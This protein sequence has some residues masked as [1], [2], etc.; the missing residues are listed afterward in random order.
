MLHKMIN[1][2]KKKLNSEGIKCTLEIRYK[3]IY[4]V[5]K[6]MLNCSTIENIHDLLGIVVT[7]KNSRDCYLSLM[8]IHS[9]Y[10]R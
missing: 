5:Y 1:E 8:I 6:K 2:T 10:V 7:V 4:S 3:D 9:L